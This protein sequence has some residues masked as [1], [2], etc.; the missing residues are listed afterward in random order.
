MAVVNYIL[1]ENRV[2]MKQMFKINIKK[3]DFCKW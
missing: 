2:D 1:E 3:F